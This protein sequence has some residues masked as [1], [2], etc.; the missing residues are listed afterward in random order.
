MIRSPDPN[1][2]TAWLI[3]ATLRDAAAAAKDVAPQLRFTRYQES[4]PFMVSYG[5]V[6][7]AAT[8]SESIE[9]VRSCFLELS[10]SAEGQ[11]KLDRIGL[12]QGFVAYDQ[13]AFVAPGTC[14]GLQACPCAAAALAATA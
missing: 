7:V 3:R 14:L 9:I 2:I 11:F 4:I 5:L 8:A 12:K 6:D 1:L 10:T 13:A